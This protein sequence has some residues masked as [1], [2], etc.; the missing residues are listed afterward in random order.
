MPLW[1]PVTLIGLLVMYRYRDVL[2]RFAVFLK[3]PFKKL[4]KRDLKWRMG[5]RWNHVVN[6]LRFNHTT[7]WN[8]IIM[9]GRLFICSVFKHR[10][11]DW[12]T[13]KYVGGERS[14]K[15]SVCHAVH[16]KRGEEERYHDGHNSH[17]PEIRDSYAVFKR[18]AGVDK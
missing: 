9:S 8:L 7:T 18:H 10:W 5:M 1:V 6:E 4:D 15:C 16:T 2:V 14:R 17:W 13:V 12:E 11:A 3:E